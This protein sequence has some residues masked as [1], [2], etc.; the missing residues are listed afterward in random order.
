MFF[1]VERILLDCELRELSE[2]FEWIDEKKIYSC[3]CSIDI[4]ARYK[5]KAIRQKKY[6]CRCSEMKVLYNLYKITL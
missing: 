3:T 2:L 5:L 1:F 6:A 4:S